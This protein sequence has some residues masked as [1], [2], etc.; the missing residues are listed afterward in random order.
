MTLVLRK[1][2]GQ[3]QGGIASSGSLDAL[4]SRLGAVR[5]PAH[6]LSAPGGHSAHPTGSARSAGVLHTHLSASGVVNWARAFA[7]TVSIAFGLP[8]FVDAA[9]SLEIGDVLKVL[10]R[11]ERRWG[12]VKRCTRLTRRPLLSARTSAHVGGQDQ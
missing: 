4:K 7:S 3:D 10:A 6:A 2:R 8:S 5:G 9:L 1:Q 11:T 12:G